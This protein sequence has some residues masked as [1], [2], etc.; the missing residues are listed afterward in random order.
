M[1]NGIYLSTAECRCLRCSIVV[2]IVYGLRKNV[3]VVII[4]FLL[5]FES[6]FR[7]TL[8]RIFYCLPLVYLYYTTFY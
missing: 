6:D 8:I 2:I 5:F 7:S 1:K 3:D 4:C